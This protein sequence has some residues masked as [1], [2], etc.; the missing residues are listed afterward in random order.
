MGLALQTL[1]YVDYG[2]QEWQ[3]CHGMAKII[4]RHPTGMARSLGLFQPLTSF[5]QL[6]SLG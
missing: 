6:S 4:S 3:N 2:I 5:P 1:L